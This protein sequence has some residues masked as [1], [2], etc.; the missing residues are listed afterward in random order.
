MAVPMLLPAQQ[1]IFLDNPSFE[2]EPSVARPPHGWYYC[3][4]AGE[5]PPDIHPGGFFGVER[6]AQDGAT[7]VGMVVRDNGTHEGIGQRLASPLQAGRCY[8]FTLYAARSE[9]YQSISRLTGAPAN[10]EQP[11]ALHIWGGFVNCARKEL[12][13]TTASIISS[14]WKPYTF[15]LQPG[16]PYTHLLIEAYYSI[17]ATPYNG[18]VLIDQASPLSLVECSSPEQKEPDLETAAVPRLETEAELRAFLQEQGRQIRFSAD[19]IMLEQHLFADERGQRHQTNRPLWLI[20]QALR[21][22]PG[23]RLLVAVGGSSGYL[24]ESHLRQ[25]EYVM[26]HTGLDERQYVL[27]ARRRSD[28]K[29]EWLWAPEEREFVMQVVER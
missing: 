3:G 20:G 15:S 19:G 29:R 24:A 28:R 25:F 11:A 22:F 26:R 7:F 17:R 6:L 14:S 27:R 23:L 21:Q 2:D 13:A 5:T 8:S 4:Q 16:E 1:V 10:Y 12:L 9:T 18:N